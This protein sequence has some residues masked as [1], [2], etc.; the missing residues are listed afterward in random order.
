MH[1]GIS[2]R[3]CVVFWM[4]LSLCKALKDSA[5]SG[6]LPYPIYLPRWDATNASIEVQMLLSS[7]QIIKCIHLGT[8][9]DVN[10]L[11]AALHDVY[12]PPGGKKKT[13]EKQSK[14]GKMDYLKKL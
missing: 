5:G 4:M 6:A 11:V 7:E 12:Q 3:F 14:Q 2:I 8:V 9:A 10:S 13:K 1:L